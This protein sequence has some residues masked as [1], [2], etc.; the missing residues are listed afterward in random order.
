MF[1]DL[2]KQ[3]E[4]NAVKA[5]KDQRLQNWLPLLKQDL[6]VLASLK[7]EDVNGIVW[8]TP[9]N[10]PY[11]YNN[12]IPS[13]N[14]SN[15]LNH[16]LTKLNSNLSSLVSN[17][18]HNSWQNWYN[19]FSFY[20]QLLHT[21]LSDFGFDIRY[22][23]EI[24]KR[25]I[26]EVRKGLKQI[27]SLLKDAETQKAKI[28]EILEEVENAIEK[29]EAIEE[30]YAKIS[31]IKE[32]LEQLQDR[33]SEVEEEYQEFI[34]RKSIFETALDEIGELKE[35]LS[36]IKDE[37]EKRQG[38]FDEFLENAKEMLDKFRQEQ[39]KELTMQVEEGRKKL[40]KIEEYKDQA[41]QT[42][43]WTEIA[44]LK[45]AYEI[46]AEDLEEKARKG[47][48]IFIG[49]SLLIA[50]YSVGVVYGGEYFFK[51]N[52]SW[53]LI[54]RVALVAPALYLGWKLWN[55]YRETKL[56]A[57][58]YTH[59]KIL[60]ENLMIG[61]ETL[62]ERLG[63]EEEETKEKFLDPTLAKLLED[64]IEKVYK[65]KVKDEFELSF[66]EKLGIK[67]RKEGVEKYEYKSEE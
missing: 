44:G 16:I 58:E 65:L 42:L 64:P 63:V 31:S 41:K 17:P 2:I 37:L 48:W 9:P 7:Q 4:K 54:A 19:T 52:G 13:G 5:E 53:F 60:A 57:D 3:L 56:L 21:L 20:L 34:E 66:L 55:N 28:N 35:S 8:Y 15:V 22:R 59:K 62:R 46:R 29:T 25:G 32:G 33:K 36:G 43:R 49:F 26:S 11:P 61:A 39:E 23:K 38:R 51:D 1:D 14:L 40:E 18:N 67:R 47:F 10:L 24:V 12:N 45:T 27:E 50:I 30:I 6:G